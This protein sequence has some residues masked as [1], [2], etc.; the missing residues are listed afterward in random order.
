MKKNF[1]TKIN[2]LI[3]TLSIIIPCY[4]IT[5]QLHQFLVSI[6]QANVLTSLRYLRLNKLFPHV[7]STS[8]HST[9]TKTAILENTTPGSFSNLQKHY[10]CSPAPLKLEPSLADKRNIRLLLER[11]HLFTAEQQKKLLTQHELYFENLHTSLLEKAGWSEESKNLIEKI[12][13][14]KFQ[15]IYNCMTFSKEVINFFK[16]PSLYSKNLDEQMAFFKKNKKE[17]ISKDYRAIEILLKCINAHKEKTAFPLFIARHTPTFALSYAKIF[18]DLFGKEEKEEIIKSYAQKIIIDLEKEDPSFHTISNKDLTLL[19]DSKNWENFSSFLTTLLFNVQSSRI[20]VKIIIEYPE[21]LSIE[22]KEKL[23]KDYPYN[24]FKNMKQKSP[25]S[26]NYL[27]N[28]Q[29]FHLELLSS[30]LKH[31]HF[32]KLLPSIIEHAENE[33]SND[34]ILLFHGQ[35]AFW[36]LLEKLYHKLSNLDQDQKYP[37]NFAHLR[38]QQNSSISKNVIQLIQNNGTEYDW[39]HNLK[40]SPIVFTNLHLAANPIGDN[41]WIAATRNHDMSGTFSFEIMFDQIFKTLNLTKEYDLLEKQFPGIFDELCK[42]F[43]D[44]IEEK[45]NHGRLLAISIPKKLAEKI[46]YPTDVMGKVYNRYLEGTKMYT[47]NTVE[48]AKNYDRVIDLNQFALILTE[49]IINPE[50]A[51]QAGVKIVGF[52]PAFY[53]KTEKSLKVLEKIEE[54]RQLIK[55]IKESK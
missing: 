32:Y 43:R 53:F 52:N 46:T 16:N 26:S 45:G 28:N 40:S 42:L 7:Y 18:P 41:S 17:I 21:L 35:Q 1:S 12:T 23:L 39:G 14:K 8:T 38:F 9:L 3:F 51:Q 20:F 34:K 10:P 54:I 22:Q 36:I 6:K 5:P 33:Y 49:E 25:L 15:K 31:P 11:P 55:K 48:I 13:I 47:S 37:E 27:E 2:L 44:A 30:N 50:A 4:S 19:Y 24:P 29:D